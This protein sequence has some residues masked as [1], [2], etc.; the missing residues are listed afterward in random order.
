MLIISARR[1]S[2]LFS[3]ARTFAF[4]KNM[5]MEINDWRKFA[6]ERRLVLPED[7]K[8]IKRRSGAAG[9]THRWRGGE[10]KGGAEG[11]EGGM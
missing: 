7:A 1:S 2:S 3:T 11:S 9:N 8:G 6:L 10:R 4:P 5:T